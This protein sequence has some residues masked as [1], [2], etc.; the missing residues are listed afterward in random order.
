M[1]RILYFIIAFFMMAIIGFCCFALRRQNTA[2]KKTLFY[3]NF[4]AF[5]TIA[6]QIL[7]LQNFNLVLSSFLNG[8]YYA[9]IDWFLLCFVIYLF[10]FTD[11]PVD[12]K[13]VVVFKRIVAAA[14]FLDT[15]FLALNAFTGF[16]FSLVPFFVFRKFYCWNF[17]YHF[18][19]YAHLAFCYV[20]VSLIFYGLLKKTIIT[21]KFYRTKFLTL[22]VIF[23]L[24][25]VLNGL[26]IFQDDNLDISVFLYGILSVF[27]TYYSFYSEPRN[28]EQKMLRL[29][30]ENVKNGVLCFDL[31][32]K[33]IYANKIG[34][35]FFSDEESACNELE[36][37]LESGKKFLFR[38]LEIYRNGLKF[39]L[40]EEFFVICD[41]NNLVLGYFIF[42]EDITAELNLI[43]QERYR[44]SHD[45]LTG[46]LNRSNF[47]LSAEIFLK[48]EPEVS[49]YLL[50]TDIVNFKMINDL[51]G[52]QFGDA[53]L[54]KQADVLREVS[55]ENAVI[56]R[57]SNDRF[58]VVVRKNSFKPAQAA[59]SLNNLSS[60]LNEYNYR[61]H[62]KIGLYEISDS[63]ENVNS[64]YNKAELAIRKND[65]LEKILS[66][67]S[68]SMMKNFVEEKDVVTSFDRALKEEQ[69]A[70][71]L[72]PQVSSKNGK[73]EG[74]EALVRWINPEKGVLFPNSFVPILEDSGLL[75]KLDFYIWEL[76]A[77][78]L[79]EWKE[80]GIDM[81]IA[82]N[83]SA[84]DFYHLDL[85]KIFTELVEKYKIEPRKLKLEITETVF[86]HDIKLHTQVLSKLQNRGFLI[87]MD[88]FGSGYSS[89]NMLRN[90]TVDILKI[91]MFFLSQSKNHEK[92]RLILDK[93]IKM[94]KKLGLTV[95]CEGVEN[96]E[97]A[98]FLK[99]AGCDYFQGYLYSM[100]VTVPSFEE[101]FINK[102]HDESEI[103]NLGEI[104]QKE[105]NK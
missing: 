87:E 31:H 1:A 63:Y 74:A 20:L 39:V 56:G 12:V 105:E 27:A 59:E 40:S 77:K 33:C 67:Y 81:H 28:V 71:Y 36:N 48:S 3:V 7:S 26:W 52:S 58:A 64:M 30:T 16:A 49:H 76:A 97:N 8:C 35:N 37:L 15:I 4:A 70:M 55:G 24:I 91:D 17:E 34:R 51:F 47:F 62:F 79:S 85:Y 23:S 29:V 102:N 19:F 89:L 21:N 90:L 57:I 45:L 65:D 88:D 6:L 68:T 53:L 93:I 43:N 2:L 73:I 50:C 22:L 69:F 78:K 99:E 66:F 38:N 5:F 44:S 11:T 14:A 54:R 10:V 42:F 94:A 103:R 100:P 104:G 13:S 46:L 98:K 101:M 82:V 84:K 83:I 86:M 92:G 61:I 41:S 95:I 96:E 32:K 60:F 9:S 18:L 72:Q 80:R 25:V 75:Y